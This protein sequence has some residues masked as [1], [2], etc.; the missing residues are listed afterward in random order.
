MFAKSFFKV[1]ATLTVR[2]A[3]VAA[4]SAEITT[5]IL[6]FLLHPK[7]MKLQLWQ[8]SRLLWW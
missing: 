8:Q 4:T 7:L 5:T 6:Q 3:A 2:E 1:F